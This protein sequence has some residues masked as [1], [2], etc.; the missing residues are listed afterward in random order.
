MMLRCATSWISPIAP[1][2][3]IGKEGQY[4]STAPPAA[5]TGLAATAVSSS[6]I[7]LTW[8]DSDNTE[9]GFKIERCTG[10]GCTDFAQIA[11]VGA[12]VT[13]YSNT[14]LTASTSYSYRVR[15]Y[16]AAGDSDYSNTASAVTQAAPAIPAAPT[17][18]VAT[19]VSRSQINLSWT[20]NANNETGFYIERC[21]GST[22]TNF[23]HIATLGANVTSYSNTELTA[24]T[25]YRYR[26]QAYNA[27]GKSGYS[28]IASATTPKR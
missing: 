25:T 28:N 3:A 18:L 9:Q 1:T 26:V 20:D 27:S 7:N 15:A 10:A 12:N 19:A 16:N 2:K 21:K 22:C 6:Q 14:G 13:S 4:C 23:A 24:N 8:T 17:S 5:P 11:T